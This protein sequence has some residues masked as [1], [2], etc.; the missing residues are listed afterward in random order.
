M[1][2]MIQTVK[3]FLVEEDGPTAVEYAVLL[4]LIII[5]AITILATFGGQITSIFT[6]ASTTVG[7][8]PGG[9]TGA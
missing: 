6:N 4:G 1:K 2:N 3:Q 9:A 8:V 7:D 5:G